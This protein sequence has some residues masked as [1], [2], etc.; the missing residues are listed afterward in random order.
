MIGLD[1]RMPELL[2][3]ASDGET[4]QSM[5]QWLLGHGIDVSLTNLWRA[6][7]LA[8]GPSRHGAP[9]TARP[10]DRGSNRPSRPPNPRHMAWLTAY[11]ASPSVKV[12]DIARA[13]G[14]SRQAVHGAIKALESEGL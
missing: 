3:M 4:Y 10:A 7:R 2:R 1:G 5:R 9:R 11:R 13:A 14:V 6:V 8:G 12:A